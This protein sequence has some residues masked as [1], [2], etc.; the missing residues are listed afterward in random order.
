[1]RI[2]LEDIINKKPYWQYFDVN[3]NLIYTKTF[4]VSKNRL[5]VFSE[6]SNVKVFVLDKYDQVN[7]IYEIYDKFKD[8]I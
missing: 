8:K 1:M 7:E 5:F 2:S 3:Q 6:N 4:L